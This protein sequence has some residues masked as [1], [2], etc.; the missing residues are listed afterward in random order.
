MK[1]VISSSMEKRPF[2]PVPMRVFI[3]GLIGLVL[4]INLYIIGSQMGWVVILLAR[5]SFKLITP[6]LWIATVFLVGLWWAVLHLVW[7]QCST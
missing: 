4:S 7:R 1:L 3:I 6:V 2:W 5:L